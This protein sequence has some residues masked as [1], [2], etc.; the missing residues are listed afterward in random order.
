MERGLQLTAEDKRRREVIM[1]LMCERRLDYARMSQRLG[2]DFPRTFAAEI[3]TLADLEADGIV[4]R[5]GSGLRVTSRGVPLLRVVA[6]RFDPT[7]VAGATQHSK[8]I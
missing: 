1:S 5:D 2:L 8:T 6:M 4:E 7:I 3:A